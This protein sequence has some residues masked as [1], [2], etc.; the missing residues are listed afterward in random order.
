MS[1]TPDPAQMTEEELWRAHRAPRV[2]PAAQDHC[3]GCGTKT[4]TYVGHRRGN[5]ADPVSVIAGQCE[6]DFYYHQDLG[7]LAAAG[8]LT[9]N[10][11]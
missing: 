1:T 9:R 8:G 4:T 11:S 3:P 10:K 7:W 5:P 6:C 2:K